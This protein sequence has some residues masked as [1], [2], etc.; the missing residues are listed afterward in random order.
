MDL[1]DHA[2]A[3]IQLDWVEKKLV[4]LTNRY[5]WCPKHNDHMKMYYGSEEK[6]AIAVGKFEQ[7]MEGCKFTVKATSQNFTLIFQRI[8]LKMQGA[9]F[10][11]TDESG[12]KLAHIST[13]KEV[14]G[15]GTPAYDLKVNG[16]VDVGFILLLTL[17]LSQADVAY[18]GPDIQLG[19]KKIFLFQ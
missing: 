3:N 10:L 8:G 18:T 17:A 2:I 6:G 13:R 4:A 14:T 19:G 5:D 16:N 7:T 9:I 15:R 12:L 11:G 1:N